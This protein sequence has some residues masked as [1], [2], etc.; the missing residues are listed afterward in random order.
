MT[1]KRLTL[2]RYPGGKSRIR[3]WVVEHFPSHGRYV[4]GFAGAIGLLLRKPRCGDESLIE[5]DSQQARLLKILRDDH[6]ALVDRLRPIR[7]GEDEFVTALGRLRAGDHDG[8]LELAALVYTVR[9]QSRGGEAEVF[10]RCPDRDTQAWWDNGVASIPLISERLRGV[11]IYHG[12]SLELLPALDGPDVLHYLDPPY[13]HGR[14][15]NTRLYGPHEMTECDHRRLCGVIKG[16]M[17]RV[18]LSGY[19]NPIY[20]EELADWGTESREFWLSAR[21]N[22]DARSR[23][24]KTETLWFNF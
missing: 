1:E 12:D 10:S 17:G 2:F 19:T 22:R 15:S 23:S 16:L 20:E 3:H 11:E 8:E 18:I 24:K 5:I 14:R 7:Y 13:V 9:K 4:E 6:A 21:Y